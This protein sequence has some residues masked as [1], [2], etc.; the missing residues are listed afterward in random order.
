MLSAGCFLVRP[1][2]GFL[3]GAPGA[4][5]LLV[6]FVVVLVLFGPRRL[7]EIARTLGR[8]M[9]QLRRASQEFSDQILEI[10]RPS[11]HDVPPDPAD[12]R[13]QSGS[14]GTQEPS[15]GEGGTEA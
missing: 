5:E 3:S 8:V 11:V 2:I 10:D 1:C 15:G 12:P 13:T 4:G 14:E 6:L 7:P 9:S